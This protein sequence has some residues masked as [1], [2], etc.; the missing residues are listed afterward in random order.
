MWQFA[1]MIKMQIQLPD[2]LYRKAK[3]IAEQREWSFAEVVR[4]GLEYMA[5]VYQVTETA[6]DWK[7]PVLK[8]GIFA[9]DFDQLDFKTIAASDE[10]R[11]Q[12]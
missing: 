1:I 11:V 7:M 9:A 5:V 12:R 3:A 10:V 2:Q 8:S 4:R 6:S